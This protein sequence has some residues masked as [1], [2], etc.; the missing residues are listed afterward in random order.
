[1]HLAF[2]C[3]PAKSQYYYAEAL[4]RPNC[5]FWGIKADLH[6][7]LLRCGKVQTCDQSLAGAMLMW[8]PAV[9]D[10][11]CW[12]MTL[13]SVRS[14]HINALYV[15]TLCWQYFF[16]V[17]QLTVYLTNTWVIHISLYLQVYF[18]LPEFISPVYQESDLAARILLKVLLV[19]FP[20]IFHCMYTSAS[21]PYSHFIYPPSTPHN[22][23]NWQRR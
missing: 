19:I 20:T 5:T 18:Y 22:L 11:Q 9:N 16:V 7:R 2:I 10:T 23:I 8:E 4:R 15:H 21:G 14:E 3:Y 12:L 13:L 6:S 17:V 1:M